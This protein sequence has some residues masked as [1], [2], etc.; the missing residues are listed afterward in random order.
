MTWGQHEVALPPPAP[1]RGTW[2]PFDGFEVRVDDV[3]STDSKCVSMMWRAISISPD[4]QG[5]SDPDAADRDP[6]PGPGAEVGRC[7]LDL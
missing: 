5:H 3:A 1:G 2:M 6:P 7:R 4:K